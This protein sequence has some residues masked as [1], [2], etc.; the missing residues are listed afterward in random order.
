MNRLT[1]RIVRLNWHRANC[2][3]RSKRPGLPLEIYI[4]SLLAV[5][6]FLSLVRTLFCPRFDCVWSCCICVKVIISPLCTEFNCTQIQFSALQ[7]LVWRALSQY[8]SAEIVACIFIK[9]EKKSS[10]QTA[11]R[12][13]SRRPKLRETDNGSIY[14]TEGSSV[15]TDHLVL[16]WVKATSRYI[17]SGF[18]GLRVRIDCRLILGNDRLVPA[19]SL[20]DKFIYFGEIIQLHHLLPSCLQIS[21]NGKKMIKS[22]SS[23]GTNC[24]ICCLK[25]AVVHM[26]TSAHWNMLRFQSRMTDNFLSWVFFGLE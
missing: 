3:Y 13:L 10:V 8:E 21:W 25:L 22:A 4:T 7:W 16:I 1:E 18:Y 9:V 23:D 19:L 14:T 6:G 11:T 5:P 2:G 26:R 15:P 12:G 17:L 24:P 20:L